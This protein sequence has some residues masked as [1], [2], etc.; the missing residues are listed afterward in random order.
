MSNEA[1]PQNPVAVLPPLKL[2]PLS[3]HEVRDAMVKDYAANFTRLSGEAP[4]IRD[5]E[6]IAISDLMLTDAAAR[7]A[8]PAKQPAAPE[9][10]EVAERQAKKREKL[11]GYLAELNTSLAK[12]RRRRRRSPLEINPQKVSPRF[13][14]AMARMVRILEPRDNQAKAVRRGAQALLATCSY[15]KLAEEYWV[16][17]CSYQYRH[18]PGFTWD[19]LKVRHNPYFGLSDSDAARRFQRA[20]EDIADKSTGVLGSWYTK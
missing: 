13:A 12:P 9:P 7:D 15:P 3:A 14:A 16:Q 6:R 5:I 1:P 10:E 17:H 2:R 4:D 20:V 8:K 18:L 11:Q 19:S